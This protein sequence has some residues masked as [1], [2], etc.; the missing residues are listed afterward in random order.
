MR[1]G[2]AI[3]G[4][5][6]LLVGSTAVPVGG[7]LL[8]GPAPTLEEKV[9][10]E[11]TTDLDVALYAVEPVHITIEERGPRGR[12]VV[13]DETHLDWTNLSYDGRRRVLREGFT[14]RVTIRVNG[15]I[16]WTETVSPGER[17]RL[18]VEHD[19]SVTV[20]SHSTA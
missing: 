5:F 10:S 11:V 19:G 16:R 18:R 17:Y 14:Y 15:R 7:G 4:L 6:V 13:V 1:I 3:V 8:S 12:G 20:A 9:H 2:V